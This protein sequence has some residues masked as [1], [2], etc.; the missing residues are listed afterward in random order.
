MLFDIIWN[1]NVLGGSAGLPSRKYL[2][3]PSVTSNPYGC[4]PTPTMMPSQPLNSLQSNAYPNSPYGAVQ[5]PISPIPLIP[6]NP[7]IQSASLAYDRNTIGNL[8]PLPLTYNSNQGLPSQPPVENAQSAL[9]LFT[10]NAPA[11]WNDP[12]VLNK[13]PKVPV[14][15]IILFSNYR[16]KFYLFLF[17][18]V[19]KFTIL[20]CLYN[21]FVARINVEIYIVLTYKNTKDEGET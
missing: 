15:C 13:A 8:N 4:A 11:G 14:C 19:F 21:D 3:D 9:N 16:I 12:P 10:A 17:P 6:S 2:L 7:N 18:W 5:D 1:K 20:S